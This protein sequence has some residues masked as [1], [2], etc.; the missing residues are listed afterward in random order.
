MWNG[1]WEVISGTRQEVHVVSSYTDA[2]VG[3]IHK[4]Q[5]KIFSH[6]GT[7]WHDN[8]RVEESETNMTVSSH[9]FKHIQTTTLTHCRLCERVT[10]QILWSAASSLCLRSEV[11]HVDSMMECLL[12][13]DRYLIT[14]IDP[15]EQAY[16]TA[17]LVSVHVCVF[18]CV[19]DYSP[20]LH[21]ISA[22]PSPQCADLD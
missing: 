18:V 8:T 10:K 4:S 16:F 19:C 20:P 1:I 12:Q 3:F 2:Q 15:A 7:R 9:L 13:P 6:D 11:G 5:R 17:T 22:L 14:A 21:E